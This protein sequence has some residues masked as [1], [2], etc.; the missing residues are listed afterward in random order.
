VAACATAKAK[1]E[2]PYLTIT[3]SGGAHE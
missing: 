3:F 1:I 2:E